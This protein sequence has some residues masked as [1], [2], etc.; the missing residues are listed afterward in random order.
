[1]SLNYDEHRHHH[2]CLVNPQVDHHAILITKALNMHH[3]H[4]MESQ[5]KIFAPVC[6]QFSTYSS[7]Q[8]FQEIV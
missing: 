3:P 5:I 7:M 2:L 8:I 4:L 1:M 6:E